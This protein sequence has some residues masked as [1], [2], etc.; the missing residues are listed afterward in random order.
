MSVSL[1]INTCGECPYVSH[2]GA[3]TPGG[4]QDICAH[5]NAVESFAG[6][7]Q[8]TMKPIVGDQ[9][10]PAKYH[11]EYRVVNRK[12]EPPPQCP[13]REGV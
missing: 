6:N 4:A 9:D 7:V 13:I 2:S 8:G 12:A 10:I 3:F 5:K 11:W 1:V